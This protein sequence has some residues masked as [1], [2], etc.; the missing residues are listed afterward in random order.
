MTQDPKKL[1]EP[2]DPEWRF[3]DPDWFEVVPEDKKI[4]QPKLP[5]PGEPLDQ[6]DVSD[7][8][9]NTNRPRRST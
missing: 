2:S 9:H 8:L 1:I 5:K 6:K 3:V 7:N 4:P